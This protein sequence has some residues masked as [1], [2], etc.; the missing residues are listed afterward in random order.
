MGCVFFTVT[1]S[2]QEQEYRTEQNVRLADAPELLE[3]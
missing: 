3:A 1:C 2:F